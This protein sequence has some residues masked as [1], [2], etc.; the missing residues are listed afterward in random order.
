M[1]K[2]YINETPLTL[3]R[4]TDVIIGSNTPENLVARYP[5]NPKHLFG[6]ID[7]LEKTRRLDSVTIY[8]AEY[9]Q[10][11]KDFESLYKIIEAAGGVVYQPSGKILAIFRRD[12]WDLPKGKIDPGESNEEAAVREVQEE[13]GIQDVDL[14]DYITTTHHT[15][16][17]K[18]KKRILKRTY[19]FKM[20]TSDTKLIPQTEEDIEQA[21][22]I[23]TAELLEQDEPIYNNIREV[24]LKC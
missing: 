13:T 14:G 15:Y 24:L 4:E 10:L 6:Y 18:S 5:G 20:K 2:I 7:M 12:F 9:D 3:M 23:D 8:S 1:Y 21:I 19:W 11:V 17:T 16:K 22:W